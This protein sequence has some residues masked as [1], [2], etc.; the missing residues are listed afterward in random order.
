MSVEAAVAQGVGTGEA[1][2]AS[3]ND[4]GRDERAGCGK[5]GGGRGCDERTHDLAAAKGGMRLER[6]GEKWFGVALLFFQIGVERHGK[7]SDKDAAEPSGANL[8]FG[9]GEEAVV[10]GGLQFFEGV[11]EI[12]VEVDGEFAGDFVFEENGMTE[13][14]GDDGAAEAVVRR[15][16]VATH[17]GNAAVGDSGLP[18]RDVAMILRVGILNAADRGNAHAVKVGAGF[19]GIALEIAVEG[20]IVLRD[21]ELVAGPREVVHADVQV[22]SVDKFGQAGAEDFEF[23]HPFGKMRGEGALLFFEP[24]DVGVAE[25][26]DAIGSE[27]DDLVDGVGKAIGG[28]VGEAVDEVDVDAVEAEVACGEYEIA[29]QFERLDA[30]DGL[31]DFGVEVLDAHAESV[32]AEIAKDDEMVAGGDAGV[33][34]DAD[35]GFGREGEVFASIGE[36]I[37]D[38]RRSEIGG[39]AAA[40]M[41]LHDFARAID[42]FADAGDFGFEDVDVR[43]GNGFIFLDDY[44]AGAE[45]AE[46]FAKGDVHVEGD[47]ALR[48]VGFG[49]DLLEIVGAE[50]I[51]PDGSGGIARVTRARA[52]VFCEEVFADAELVEDVGGVGKGHWRASARMGTGGG[53]IVK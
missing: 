12:G 53:G 3:A 49:V 37:V 50:R 30:V 26:G 52:I 39:S 13:E 6:L 15:E 41:E 8:V 7:V 46:A 22:T 1:R 17:G 16:A 35:F 21:G 24:G 43:R 25:E 18:T 40:P 51:V 34:F 31:L 20:A 33:D 44:V 42:I 45:E 47:G 36:E 38:L 5:S 11:C 28:L 32:E 19:G 23:L 9:D 27:G 14:A 29:R 4:D 10:E 48:C 2:H